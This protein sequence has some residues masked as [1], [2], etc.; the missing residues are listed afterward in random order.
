MAS[1]MID[2]FFF[3]HIVSDE[4]VRNVF[5]EDNA[6][7]N[8][9]DVEAAMAR[10][11]AKLGIIPQYA[12]DEICKKAKLEYL[13]RDEI[14][15]N[16]LKLEHSL[17]PFTKAVQSICEGD[18]G[19]YIHFGAT[20]Q[21]IRD[22]AMALSIKKAR[23]I[24]YRDLKKTCD[25][26]ADMAQEY[27]NTA[28]AGRTH[29]Q[30]ALPITFGYKVAVWLD[31]MQRHVTRLEETKER[32]LVGN[33]N[34]GVGT[35]ASF[36]ELGPDVE[37]LVMEDLG[38]NVPNICWQAARDRYAEFLSILAMIGSTC[39]KICNEIY[40]MQATEL[41]EVA[42]GFKKGRL[43]S[44]TMPHKRNPETCESVMSIAKIIRGNANIMLQVMETE[45]ERDGSMWRTEWILIPET[46]IY[47][48]YVIK[49]C[50]GILER[51]D[52]NGENMLK[53]LNILNGLILSEKVMFA[54]SEKVGK[55]TAHSIVYDTCMKAYEE[56]RLLTE[57]MMEDPRTCDLFTK[58][59]IEEILD[60]T[61]YVGLSSEIAE[62]VV[63]GWKD[64]EINEG[65]V[66]A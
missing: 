24:I 39:S 35:F 62:Q 43:G 21:D 56:N 38:L 48:D 6:V 28:M 52:V 37:K 14:K 32:L 8:L 60:P 40:N 64:R 17:V 26:L 3:N 59:E 11:E 7:Q 22:T 51:L 45:H 61:K 33:L 18:A 36:G 46:C 1:H 25:I 2:Q 27:K 23:E 31:E 29:G 58:E 53:N 12:A 34:G 55:Q 5:E 20:T 44:S 4:E 30:Q 19:E 16:I 49:V 41:N 50:S 13:N 47:A 54:V 65:M 9:L 57:V 10:A 15:A 63:K 66:T 42:E